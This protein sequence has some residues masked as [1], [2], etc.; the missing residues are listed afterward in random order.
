MKT[1]FF[2][3]ILFCATARGAVLLN[4]DYSS[5]TGN[6][7]ATTGSITN[8]QNEGYNFTNG[9]IGGSGVTMTN[10]FATVSS[11]DFYCSAWFYIPDTNT[12]SASGSDT[13]LYVLPDGTVGSANSAATIS[14]TRRNDAGF[15]ATTNVV[16]FTTRNP[17]GF[18][19]D[20]ITLRRM[21]WNKVSIVVHISSRTYDVYLNDI[22]WLRNISS[23]NAS[24]TSVDRLA[25]SSQSPGSSIDGVYA[26]SSWA[27]PTESVLINQDFTTSTVGDITNT[28][29]T[30]A[31]RTLYPQRWI[32]PVNT[33]TAVSLTISANGAAAASAVQS[34]AITPA[35]SQGIL[36][37]EFKTSVAGVTYFGMMFRVWDAPSS[38]GG[39]VLRISGSDN[40]M[41]LILPNAT[42]TLITVAS[43]SVTPSAN[44]TYSLKMEMRGRVLTASYKNSAM[45]S[46]SYT[47][48]FT[49]VITNST[50][51][52]R[53]MLSEEFV[54][55]YMSG[56]V[57]ASD[58]YCT[59][60]RFTGHLPD[61]EVTMHNGIYSARM[62]AGSVRE[63]Y[64]YG[65]TNNI[66][67][68]KG[69]Q[70]GHRSR[71]D[72][73][74]FATIH[75]IVF[76]NA[77]CVVIR[78][79]SQNWTEYQQLGIAEIFVTM[80]RRGIW[81]TDT[82]TPWIV[83]ENFAPDL[84][85]NPRHLFTNYL[86]ASVGDAL[87]KTNYPY[88][89]WRYDLQTTNLPG[90]HQAVSVLRVSQVV[91]NFTNWAAGVANLTH[92][93]LGIVDPVSIATDR[94]AASLTAATLYGVYRAFLFET[95]QT[96]DAT[97]MVN[98]RNDASNNAAL[99][100]FSNGSLTG[101]SLTNGWYEIA[102]TA[103][104]V[105][106]SL[107][108]G[109]TATRHQPAFKQTLFRPGWM[110]V[111][112]IGKSAITDFVSDSMSDGSWLVQY[113]SNITETATVELVENPPHGFF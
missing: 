44:S 16:G 100:S 57:G 24:Y 106:F 14:I 81:C 69:I 109:G 32:A 76:S 36:E 72:M 43:N 30:T 96:L 38:G 102:A 4:E 9:F 40:L 75:Q 107:P 56:S 5:G 22:L 41:Q 90:V 78:Q 62:S 19:S 98:W 2:T 70:M 13:F 105:S 64:A 55:P 60:I 35:L 84:D 88:E 53:G 18:S 82:V 74:P 108:L 95:N 42:G 29:P 66:F 48:A 11:G 31:T 112:G 79:R 68:S 49:H 46:G 93:Y 87:T 71:A 51:G 33:S 1:F 99:T 83:T 58:N 6:W 52:G 15:Y 111:N 65:S 50:T 28:V 103:S 80:T 77:N 104:P 26:E 113:L 63:L 3:L 25:I 45:D 54:G 110:R 8:S 37:G 101:F 47:L 85:Y 17:A 92:K 89:S 86:M 97:A 94:T 73:G 91:G 61:D 21:A 34:M 23:A 20:D 59:R 67:Q 12:V 10:G 39:G 27:L 7:V